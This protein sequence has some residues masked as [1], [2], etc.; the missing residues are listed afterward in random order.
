MNDSQQVYGLHAVQALFEQQR[1]VHSLWVLESRHDARLEALLA[2][3][4]AQ[5]VTVRRTSREA[6]D[7]LAGHGRHQGVI[8]E[9]AA[10]Q[11]GDEHDLAALLDGLAVPPFLLVLDGVT[12]PHNL[13]ACLRSANAAGVHA[14]IAPR[15]R[16]ADLTPVARKAAAGAAEM[17]PFFQVTNLTRSLRE[18]KERNIWLVG[19][20]GEADQTLYELDLKGPLAVVMGAEGGGLRRLTKAECDFLARIPMAGGIESLNVSVATGVALFEALRQRQGTGRNSGA[21]SAT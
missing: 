14:V 13:G 17:T 12:D 15:D 8:A 9:A 6:L 10:A 21:S 19:F 20:A 11:S 2:V 5:Q 1:P 18:L 16:A 7:Q 4:A 3:A